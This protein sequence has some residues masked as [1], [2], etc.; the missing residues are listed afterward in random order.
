[1]HLYLYREYLFGV[2]RKL[3]FMLIHPHCPLPIQVLSFG[4]LFFVLSTFALFVSSVQG[5]FFFKIMRKQDKEKLEEKSQF[6]LEF[7]LMKKFYLKYRNFDFEDSVL[8]KDA[9]ADADDEEI[10]IDI[11]IDHAQYDAGS[12]YHEDNIY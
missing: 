5:I 6:K 2:A 7:E 11:D 3:M 4:V 1:M 9:N 8:N 12:E 10:E